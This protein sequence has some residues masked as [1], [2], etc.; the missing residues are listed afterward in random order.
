MQI[1]GESWTGKLERVNRECVPS[2]IL[3][4]SDRVACRFGRGAPY[5]CFDRHSESLGKG[6]VTRIP[7]GSATVASCPNLGSVCRRN[8]SLKPYRAAACR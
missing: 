3:S 7:I 1:V 8:Q 5:Q 4:K 2:T 6:G